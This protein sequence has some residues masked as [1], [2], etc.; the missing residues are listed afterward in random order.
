MKTMKHTSPLAKTLAAA[1]LAGVLMISA[2]GLPSAHVHA[3]TQTAASTD[4]VKAPTAAPQ[5]VT[6]KHCNPR[7]NGSKRISRFLYSRVWP[8]PST[9]IS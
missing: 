2:S 9:K 7:K 4:Q 1:G 8:T 6:F 3:E 5:R